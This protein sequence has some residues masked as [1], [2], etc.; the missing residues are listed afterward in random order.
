MKRLISGLLSFIIIFYTGTSL[1]QDPQRIALR[2]VFEGLKAPV[3]M[4][5]A[6]D[7]SGRLFVVEKGGIVRVIKNNKLQ[8]DSYL[9]IEDLVSKGSEQGLLSIAFPPDFKQTKHFF[10]N[11]TDVH[12]DTLIG[13][14]KEESPEE[15]DPESLKVVLKIVQPYTNHN[16]GLILFGPDNNMYIGMGD[17]GSS[18]DPDS[19]AQNPSSMLGKILRV[20]IQPDGSYS[21][22]TDNPFVADKKYL[23]EIWALGMRNPWRFSFDAETG[24]L[25]AGDVGQDSEEE[26][27]IIEKGRNYGWNLVEGKSC[28]KK[29]CD[30]KKFTA[31]IATYGRTEGASVIGGHVYRGKKVPGLIGHYVFGDYVSGKIWSLTEKP[32]HEWEQKLVFDLKQPITSFAEDKDKELYVL[33]HTG[34]IYAL[35]GSAK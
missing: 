28:F 22:P 35:E 8:S 2:P 21:V 32:N 18:G 19:Y 16:G 3:Y 27:D 26:I 9:D 31:P 12:G 24:R 11:Y 14:F 20:S 25:F 4:T 33:T 10:V 13:M 7:D 5:Y 30:L 1:A 34:V 23:P 15:A 6:P 17:G 29:D